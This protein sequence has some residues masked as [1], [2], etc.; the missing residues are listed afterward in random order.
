MEPV[1]RLTRPND[2]NTLK[3]LDLKTHQYPMP[4]EEWQKRI[5]GSGKKDEA[6]IVVC[7]VSKIAVGFAMWSIDFEQKF[8][9]LLRLG[10]LPDFRGR[11]I[12]RVLVHKCAQH[13]HENQ[14]EKIKIVV[15]HVNCCPGDPDDV[16]TFLGKVEFHATGEIIHNWRVMYGDDI[17]GYIFERSLY[18]TAP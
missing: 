16:S 1:I 9:H 14:C 12:G 10:V 8:S 11:G 13:S 15:P 4:L 18:V 2:I 17:D 7:E 5:N 3:A 6:R